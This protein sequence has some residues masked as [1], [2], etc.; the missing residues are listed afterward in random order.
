MCHRTL[1]TTLFAIL[2][3]SVSVGL[4]A[5]TV[6]RVI[7]DDGVSVVGS[8]VR[9]VDSGEDVSCGELDENGSFSI[10][11]GFC[12]ENPAFRIKP[13]TDDYYQSRK[14]AS[15]KIVENATYTIMIWK[16]AYIDNLKWNAS[17]FEEKEDYAKASL[18]RN[19]IYQRLRGIDDAAAEEAR[20]KTIRLFA[21]Y[22]NNDTPF[23]TDPLQT[24]PV[25][26][27]T[28]HSAIKQFQ[29]EKGIEDT[30]RIDMRTLRTAA[31]ISVGRY[32]F[33]R[34]EE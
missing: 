6:C 29:Q 3:F 9:I 33:G 17:H 13:K 32:L 34:A 2:V 16:K 25:I 23:A 30:G 1:F 4:R 26:N 19:E 18:M 7:D 14:Y 11:D 20:Q 8:I 24:Q 22:L 5:E 28:F 15:E 10:N 31:G 27:Q 12:K 21:R